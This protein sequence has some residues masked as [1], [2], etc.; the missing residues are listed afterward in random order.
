MAR[1]AEKNDDFE[2]FLAACEKEMSEL[3]VGSNKPKRKAMIR[4]KCSTKWMSMPQQIKDTFKENGQSKTD[5]DHDLLDQ[6]YEIIKEVAQMEAAIG[7]EISEQDNSSSGVEPLPEETRATTKT[8]K[9]NKVEE[10]YNEPMPQNQKTLAVS[11]AS[12]KGKKKADKKTLQPIL[13]DVAELSPIKE[14]SAL[15]PPADN[16]T[17]DKAKSKKRSGKKEK[18]KTL[19]ETEVAPRDK[20]LSPPAENDQETSG[21]ATSKKR[22]GKKEKPKTLEKTEAEL[23]PMNEN[24]AVIPPADDESSDKA[25]SKKRT[26]KKEKPKTLE[27]TE[28]QPESDEVKSQSTAKSTRTRSK[29]AK[30]L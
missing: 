6:T 28:V 3:H 13:S 18:S 10:R 20:T 11:A 19:E 24:S 17:S 29:P 16:E 5:E 2:R 8:A 4:S 22:S 23:S 12:G 30:L 25:K 9:L 7:D 1:F 21:R 14:N 27:E 26:G 15:I